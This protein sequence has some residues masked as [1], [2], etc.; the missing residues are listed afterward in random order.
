MTGPVVT[1]ARVEALR[2]RNL[3]PDWAYGK[4]QV[5]AL[6]GVLVTLTAEDGTEGHGYAPVL[7]H[8][9][10]T[11][12]VLMAGTEALAKVVVG[13]PALSPSVAAQRMDRRMGGARAARSAVECA[14]QDLAA[15]VLGVPLHVLFGGAVRNRIPLV[16]IVPLKTPPAMAEAAAAIAAEGYRSIKLKASGD[17]ALDLARVRAVREAVGQ[18][19][20][21]MVDANQAY[22]TKGAIGFAQAAKAEG[23]TWVEQPVPANDLAGLALATR[24]SPIGVEADEAVATSED[25]VRLAAT[26]AVDGISLKVTKSGGLA[27]VAAMAAVAAASGLRCRMGTAFGSALIAAHSAHLVAALPALTGYAECAEFAHFDGD[28]FE[29][30]AIEDGCLILPAGAGSGLKRL[31]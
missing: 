11:A 27:P 19:V 2:L 4:V 28:V 21:L 5:P 16:R 29:A 6:D 10:V 3:D 8:L 9:A 26:R 15:R 24:E 23:V 1:A 14:T 18:D 31:K 7:S 13:A 20:D 25:V 17:R 22:D 12:E 30:P